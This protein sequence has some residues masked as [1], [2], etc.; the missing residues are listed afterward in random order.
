M[1]AVAVL[2]K[3]G[4]LPLPLH[5]DVQQALI[6]MSGCLGQALVELIKLH[7]QGCSLDPGLITL[8]T[9]AFLERGSPW[10][11]TRRGSF[12][13]CPSDPLLLSAHPRPWAAL[14]AF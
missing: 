5:L 4:H 6:K 12:R 3:L 11:Q 9:E 8:F 14:S 2:A 1:P 13:T 10:A 7:A